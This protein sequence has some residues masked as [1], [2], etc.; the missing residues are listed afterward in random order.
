MVLS[1]EF[2]ALPAFKKI[3]EKF[4]LA[5]YQCTGTLESKINKCIPKEQTAGINQTKG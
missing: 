1:A 4:K 3:I 5:T 2:I